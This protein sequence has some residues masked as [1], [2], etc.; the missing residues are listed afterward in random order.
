MVNKISPL[1]ECT[2]VESFSNFINQLNVKIGTFGGRRFE[3]D[4]K[5]SFTMREILNRFELLVHSPSSYKD[6]SKSVFQ[7]VKDLNESA[8]NALCHS[9]FFKRAMTA[10]KHAFNSLT[11]NYANTCARIETVLGF[12]PNKENKTDFTNMQ[13]P[14]GATDDQ[15]YDLSH[16][17]FTESSMTKLFENLKNLKSTSSIELK[18]NDQSAAL[19][20]KNA[21]QHQLISE[22]AHALPELKSFTIANEQIK[23][24]RDYLSSNVKKLFAL[25]K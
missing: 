5:N 23:T 3:L 14:V 22:L 7:N 24:N 17:N 2:S 13:Y 1:N 4:G 16:I 12:L 15:V 8:N 21:S 19:L 9:S 25:R 11:F 10:I 6:V 18:L 20:Q